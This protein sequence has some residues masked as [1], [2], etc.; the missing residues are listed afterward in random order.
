[1][2]VGLLRNPAKSPPCAVSYG[3]SNPKYHLPND[4]P[5][6]GTGIT[7]VTGR[8]HIGSLQDAESLAGNNPHQI[9]TVITLCEE[10]VERRTPGIRYRHLPILDSRPVQPRRLQHIL[11]ALE[12]AVHNGAVLLHC[13]AGVSR[14]PTIAAAYLHHIGFQ[15]FTRAIA[16]LA[17]IRPEI[18]P[19]PVLVDSVIRQLPAFVCVDSK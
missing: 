4:C 16:Y 1:M 6:D 15:E 10:R 18:G 8:L 17:D 13:A 14:T 5:I 9:Q 12:E 7:P 11:C 19:S 3:V 2:S